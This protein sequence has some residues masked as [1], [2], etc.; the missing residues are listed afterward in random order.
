MDSCAEQGRENRFFV[1]NCVWSG[2][3]ER[4]KDGDGDKDWKTE[5]DCGEIKESMIGGRDRAVDGTGL[6]QGPT[7]ASQHHEMTRTR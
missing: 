2:L 3:F 1:V 6:L 7:R 4:L 5:R